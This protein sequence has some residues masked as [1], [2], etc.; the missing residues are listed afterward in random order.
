MSN[1]QVPQC[2]ASWGLG[3]EVTI[4]NNLDQHSLSLSG[5]FRIIQEEQGCYSGNRARHYSKDSRSF[6][7]TP[8]RVSQEKDMSLFRRVVLNVAKQL[9]FTP[10]DRFDMLWNVSFCWGVVDFLEENGTTFPAGSRQAACCLFTLYDVTQNGIQ[11]PADD[12]DEINCALVI[13]EALLAER[14]SHNLHAT[15]E[16]DLTE[17]NYALRLGE[18]EYE[19][20]SRDEEQKIVWRVRRGEKVPEA[21]YTIR[22]YTRMSA[23][24][25]PRG[26]RGHVTP[27]I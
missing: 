12:Q 23:P 22:W 9:P 2:S 20:R 11:R 4:Q 16:K 1:S 17:I 27:L 25:A 26:F 10:D 7:D 13:S 24:N 21:T 15:P 8:S 5:T 18:Y 3:S 6:N 14:L 19:E